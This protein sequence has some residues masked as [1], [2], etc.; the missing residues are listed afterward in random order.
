MWK[1]EKLATKTVK[2]ESFTEGDGL[3]K[4]GRV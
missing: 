1:G 4:K 2:K 3:G